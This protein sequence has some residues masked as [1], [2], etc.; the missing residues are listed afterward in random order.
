MQTLQYRKSR[1][2][3]IH[4]KEIYG[5]YFTAVPSGGGGEFSIKGSLDFG[6]RFFFF[7]FQ[8]AISIGAFRVANDLLI[9]DASIRVINNQAYTNNWASNLGFNQNSPRF[10]STNNWESVLE[11]NE[12][13]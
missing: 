9:G 1:L 5:G 11:Q 12:S 2:K 8:T 10:S 3:Q 6:K 4:H 7:T 13:A